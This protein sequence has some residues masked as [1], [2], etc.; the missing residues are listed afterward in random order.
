MVYSCSI[1]MIGKQRNG[2]PRLWCVVHRAQARTFDRCIRATEPT[3]P[4]TKVKVELAK[5]PGGVALWGA[6]PPVINTAT[7]PGESGV[8][9]HARRVAAG[10]KKID[11]TFDEVTVIDGDNEIRVTATSATAFNISRLF[12]QNVKY[13]QCPRCE[14]AH[15]DAGE[16]AARPHRKHLCL[17]CGRDFYD[18]EP[19]IGNPIALVAARYEV[20]RRVVPARRQL[21]ARHAEFSGGFQVWGTHPAILW[22]APVPEE[23]GIHVHGFKGDSEA[24]CVDETYDDVEIEGV[25]LHAAQIRLLMAQMAIP[26]LAER[27]ISAECPRCSTPQFDVGVDAII[28]RRERKCATCGC[29]FEA[30]GR[31]KIAISNPMLSAAMSINAIRARVRKTR[32]KSPA[33]S[34]PRHAS[35]DRRRVRLPS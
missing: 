10:K 13:L 21:I 22:T 6:L 11:A 2:A 35:V 4:P 18:S 12:G 15:I 28:A 19:S 9:V 26:G 1:S 33:R 31:R 30:T 14:E 29:T 20:G 27:L 7:A 23:S 8:H 25:R 24:P 32:S 17:A 34:R 3:T 5:Y 16:F